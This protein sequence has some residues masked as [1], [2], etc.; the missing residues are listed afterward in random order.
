MVRKILIVKPD[1]KFATTHKPFPIFVKFLIMSKI[2]V[3]DKS[4]SSYCFIDPDFLFFC[5]IDFRFEAL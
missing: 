2:E 5:R 3:I 1:S 4:T